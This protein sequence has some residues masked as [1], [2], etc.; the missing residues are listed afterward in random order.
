MPQGFKKVI[1]ILH[2][3]R[4]C[5]PAERQTCNH[6]IFVVHQIHDALVV[7]SVPEEVRWVQRILRRV[8]KKVAPKRF[9]ITIPL[10]V[11]MEVS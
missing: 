7:D 5:E 3:P 1:A 4:L 2:L 9:G 6:G 8:M 11:D 10:E